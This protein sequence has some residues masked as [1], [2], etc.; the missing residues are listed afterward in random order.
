MHNKGE[1]AASML[2]QT[3]KPITIIGV[4]LSFNDLTSH[5]LSLVQHADILI[6][7]LRLLDLFPEHPGEKI[8]VTKD[9]P[10]LIER[11]TKDMS[12]KKI[13]VLA[14][15]D[16][17]FF[18]V[19]ATLIKALP[20]EYIE[21]YPNISSV[22]A[23]FARL[24]TG[25]NDASFV[26]M[27]GKK[28]LSALLTHMG[29]GNKI[30]VLTDPFNSPAR[31]AQFL[32]RLGINGWDMH[33]FEQLGS[34]RER[35]K[36]YEMEEAAQAECASPNVTILIK[37]NECQKPKYPH[38]LGAPDEWYVHEKGLITKAEVRS[39]SLSRLRLSSGLVVWDLGAGS[40]S[41]SVEAALLCS[42]GVIFS[43]ERNKNRLDMIVE[44]TKRFGVRN[45]ISVHADL[46]EG[47]DE[48]PD[49][50]RIFIGGGGKH[51]NKIADRALARL[52]PGGVIVINTVLLENIEASR[53]L[54]TARG[55]NPKT[56]LVQVSRDIAMPFGSRMEALN[57]VWIITGIKPDEREEHNAP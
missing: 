9:I 57:P 42:G 12:E 11:I 36:I 27:H 13:V 4:G 14:S 30:A 17:L 6:G 33:V 39:V 31:I 22:A 50:D 1:K 18:G 47:M 54:L 35:H 29:K 38:I 40:G 52:K 37:R 15:G 5:H 19:G 21:I 23:A 7:G 48:L 3:M 44:N 25:W 55:L 41:V 45:L 20:P 46:P 24:K 53:S 56:T 8:P 49:P 16:P 2:K 28:D 10:G 34:E 26:S 51:L 32:M 43:V